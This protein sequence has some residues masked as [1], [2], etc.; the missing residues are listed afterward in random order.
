MGE[1]GVCL[2]KR[3]RKE[4]GLEISVVRV[5]N[6]YLWFMIEKMGF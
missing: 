2:R 3:S 6:P 1:S 5:S 4:K